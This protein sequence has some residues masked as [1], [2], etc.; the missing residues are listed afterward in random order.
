VAHRYPPPAATACTQHISRQNAPRAVLVA[1]PAPPLSLP[2]PPL[3]SAAASQ[4][5]M[6][7]EE[8]ASSLLPSSQLIKQTLAYAKELE[9][10]V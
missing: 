2:L 1:P 7:A 8:K 9:R 6:A 4:V 10:I 3:T 5:L